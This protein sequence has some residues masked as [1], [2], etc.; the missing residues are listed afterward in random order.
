MTYYLATTETKVR[1]YK[2]TASVD[3]SPGEFELLDILDLRQLPAFGD[4][5]TAKQAALALGLKVWRYVRL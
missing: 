5:H 3:L 2:F 1:W 4:K